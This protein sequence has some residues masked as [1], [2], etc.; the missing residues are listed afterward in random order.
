MPLRS[1]AP[2]PPPGASSALP[3]ALLVGRSRFDAHASSGYHPGAP[4]APRRCPRRG[5]A[6]H[7]SPGSRSTAREATDEESS[8]GA[9]PCV[10]RGTREASW[11]THPPRRRHL[12]R[13]RERS[14]RAHRCRFSRLDGRT[15]RRS[16][17]TQT[18]HAARRRPPSPT[19]PP[20]PPRAGHGLLL[21]EQRRRGR[22]ACPRAR[23][24]A[25]PGARLGRPSWQ[26]HPGR[27]SGATRTSSTCRPTSGPSTR[28]PAR[29]GSGARGQAT[30]S[31]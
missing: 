18:H 25:R 11:C 6:G 13:P 24:V 9:R 7:A 15:D 21:I 2:P 5:R 29:R 1:S 8:R 22:G 28:A 19:G 4:G 10:H 14:R 27:C 23:C 31:R 16:A 12:R 30:A 17:D 3:R 20:R 26:R